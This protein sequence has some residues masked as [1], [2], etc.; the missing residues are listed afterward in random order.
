MTPD[1]IEADDWD[2]VHTLALALVNSDEK[3][4]ERRTRRQLLKYLQSLRVKYGDQAS[5][6]ATAADYADD[7]MESERLL[8]RAFDVARQTSDRRD[9]LFVALS[10]ADL[11]IEEIE[12]ISKR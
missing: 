6:L 4:E 1:G 5:L 10:L 11:Y 7:S 3:D 8:L 12:D 9:E 2:H